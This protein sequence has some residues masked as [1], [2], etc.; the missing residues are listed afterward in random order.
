MSLFTCA[1][2]VADSYER[3]AIDERGAGTSTRL[4]AYVDVDFAVTLVFVIIFVLRA[5]VRW[6]APKASVLVRG[7]V[8]AA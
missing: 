5:Y 4:Q 1:L 8:V 3:L 7:R 6:I 2:Y